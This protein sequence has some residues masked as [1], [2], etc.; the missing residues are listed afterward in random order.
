[1]VTVQQ[2]RSSVAHPLPPEGLDRPLCG[3]CWIVKGDWE[4][5]HDLVTSDQGDPDCDLVHAHLHRE[6]GE[7]DSA[8]GWY[9]SSG[10]PFTAIPLDAEWQAI[11][12]RLLCR[13]G[14]S[15]LDLS[16]SNTAQAADLTAAPSTP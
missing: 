16:S 6:R 3:L 15:N 10:E 14:W 5:A 13:P 8:R 7:I 9:A 4:R 2:F 11:A 12:E 1:M